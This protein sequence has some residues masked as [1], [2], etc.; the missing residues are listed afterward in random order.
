MYMK[1]VNKRDNQGNVIN[2]V[3]YRNEDGLINGNISDDISYKYD[4]LGNR[5]ETIFTNYDSDNS[6][7]GHPSSHKYYYNEDGTIEKK[8]IYKNGELIE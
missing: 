3:T 2:I 8:S 5:I 6:I 7:I 4:D 1:T